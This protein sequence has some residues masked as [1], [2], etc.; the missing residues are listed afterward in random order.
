MFERGIETAITYLDELAQLSQ[1]ART[2]A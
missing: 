2:A 1:P